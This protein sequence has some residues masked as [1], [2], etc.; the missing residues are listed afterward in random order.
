ME[1]VTT[2]KAPHQFQVLGGVFNDEDQLIRHGA[3]ES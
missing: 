1:R 2:I 3:P